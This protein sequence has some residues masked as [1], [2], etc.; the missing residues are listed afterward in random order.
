MNS[1]EP[2]LL[3]VRESKE[4]FRYILEMKGVFCHDRKICRRRRLRLGSVRVFPGRG[5]SR[6][7]FPAGPALANNADRGGMRSRLASRPLGRLPPELGAR[8]PALLVSA[9]ALGT[10]P[11]LP[12]V[13]RPARKP[14]SAG[15]SF[16][17][18]YPF[19]SR[20]SFLHSFEEAAERGA[21][22]WA[23]TIAASGRRRGRETDP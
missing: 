4:C 10:A 20:F 5:A 8:R 15:F 21:I 19:R 6:L 14:C 17:V 9:D 2:F 18:N 16:A 1:K 3:L 7:P 13:I 11:R 23:A 22:H 12:L